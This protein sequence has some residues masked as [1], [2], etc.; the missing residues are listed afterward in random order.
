VAKSLT[1]I[2]ALSPIPPFPENT[3]RLRL[4]GLVAPM[5]VVSLFVTSYMFV[6][7]VTFGIGFGFFGDPIISRSIDWL[8]RAYPNWQKLLELRK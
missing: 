8:N 6:K 3:Y 7:G 1:G 4:A 5:F 2:S